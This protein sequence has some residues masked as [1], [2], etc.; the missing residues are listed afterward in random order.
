MHAAGCLAA[1]AQD[2]YPVGKLNVIGDHGSAITERREV[3]GRIEAECASDA[4]RSDGAAIRGC[5]VCL[6]A[7]LDNREAMARCHRCQRG[8]V[9]GLPIEM[10][11]QYRPRARGYGS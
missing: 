5:E 2:P 1:V 9:G 10:D 11:R 6:T 3:L 4:Y 8:H 7:V